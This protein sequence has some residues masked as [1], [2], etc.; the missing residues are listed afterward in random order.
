[1]VQ[2]HEKVKVANK[3]LATNS[4]KIE[5]SIKEHLNELGQGARIVIRPSGTEN[6]VRIMVEAK[7]K[8]LADKSMLQLIDVVKDS[9]KE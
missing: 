6:V 2:L 9:C 5:L 1:M 4:D 8:S 7:D 3:S